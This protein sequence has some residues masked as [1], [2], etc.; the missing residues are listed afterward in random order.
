M[1]V[2]KKI[3]RVLII[4]CVLFFLIVAYLTYWQI[5]EGE[6]MMQNVYNRRNNEIEENT[7]RGSILDRNEVVLAY[8]EKNG[9]VYE[10]VYPYGALYSHVIGYDSRVYGKSLL[11]ASYNSYLLGID[12]YS[13]VF[14]MIDRESK[15][16][17]IYVTLDH[18]LQK[19]GESLLKDKIGAIVAIDPKSGEV[20]SL[21]S[22]PNFDTNDKWLEENWVGIVESDKAI[23]LPRATQ[24][25]YAPGSTF[26]VITTVGAIENEFDKEVFEDKGTVIIDGYEIRNAGKRALGSIDIKKALAASSNVV[27]SQ[28]G[29]KLGSDQL[30]DLA[31]RIGMNRDIPF[32]ITVNKSIFPY[33][34]MGENDMAAVAIGQGEMVFTPFHM[35]MVAAGIAN[36]GK[37]MKPVL[38]KS[39]ESPDEK[40]IES[41]KI[42]ILYEI[43]EQETANTIKEMMY[44]AIENGTGRSAKVGNISVAG[45]TGTAEN[46]LSEKNKDKEHAWFIGFAPVEDPEIAVAVVVEHGGSGSG[47]SAPIAGEIMNEYLQNLK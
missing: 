28:I 33:D 5:F 16:N 8:S 44:E 7:M 43:M 32:D 21:V 15:G 14:G 35:A 36:E 23:L 24:G 27:Y 6:N 29:V 1:D 18:R 25:L 12:R 38:V 2:N 45:K 10:R 19:L 37:V 3:I 4:M 47:V 30:K 20:L 40:E 41:A 11:E 31:N 26:K 46:N 9:D 34:S 42:D 17:N 22:K 39:V 13:Q